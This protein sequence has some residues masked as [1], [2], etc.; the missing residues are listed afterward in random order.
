[1][2]HSSSPLDIVATGHSCGCHDAHVHEDPV[3]DA[4]V[5]PH[6]VRHGAI[7]GAVDALPPGGALVLVAPHDP[8]PLLAQA[9][10]RYGESLSV[11]YLQRGPDAWHVRL[12]R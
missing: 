5:I 4:R 6:A 1:M 8:L 10:Q 9:Q 7:F 2:T 11:E 3:L 12:R